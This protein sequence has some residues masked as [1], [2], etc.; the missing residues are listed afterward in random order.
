MKTIYSS[1]IIFALFALMTLATG[2]NALA[3]IASP[4]PFEFRQSDGKMVT[5]RM[6]GD[7]YVRWAETMDHYTLLHN[8]N[9]YWEYAVQDRNGDIIPS[10]L[11]AHNNDERG[12]EEISL[13]SRTE[14]SLRY[15]RQQ[16]GYLKSL[17][18][19]KQPGAAAGWNMNGT[20]KMVV[21]LIG[22]TDRAFMKT[23]TDFTN[24]MNQV[25]YNVGT[26]KGS[27][28][29]AFLEYSY[30]QFTLN[31]T[32]V[33]PYMA[34]HNEAYYGTNTPSQDYRVKELVTEA[35]NLANPVVNYAE[36]DNNNDGEAEGVYV[37]HA[38]YGEHSGGGANAIWGQMNYLNTPV[39][40]DGKTITPFTISC[41]LR[42]N[43]GTTI[44]SIGLMC[45]EFGHHLGALDYYD[46][47]NTTNGQY[48][49][50]EK[51]DLMGA[52]TWNDNGDRPSHPNPHVKSKVYNWVNATVVNS[53][54]DITLRDI[55]YYPDIYQV[56]TTTA[57]E[58]YL[59]ENKRLTGFN[60]NC[61]GE[62]ML[63][64]H[65]DANHIA[66]N[67]GSINAGPHQG[68]Y[69]MSAIS[70]TA[71]GVMPSSSS[72]INTAGC[73]WPGTGNKTTFS[74]ATV[75]NQKSWAGNNT[76]KAFINIAENGGNITFCVIGCDV[77][78]PGS[79]TV[80][81][82]SSSQLNLSWTKNPS[83]SPVMVAVNSVNSFGNPV[84][85]S[86]YS[87]GSLIAGGGTVIYYNGS[88]LGYNHT[89]LSPQTVY[90]YKVWS[91]MPGNA[92][93]AGILNNG[94][95]LCGIHNPPYTQGFS[96]TTLPECWTQV[97]NTG[98]GKFWQ[99][100]IHP[101][102]PNNQLTGNYAYMNSYSTGSPG[103]WNSDLISPLFNFSN[104][105][106]VTLQF[107]HYFESANVSVAQVSYTINNGA[108]WTPLQTWTASIAN[109]THFSQVIAGA[110]GQAQVRFKWN[111]ATPVAAYF[112]EIDNISV[113]VAP[114]VI[115]APVSNIT[116]TSAT[117]GGDVISDGGRAV[118]ARGVCWG[119]SANPTISGNHTTNGSGTGSFIAA[120]AGLPQ[121]AWLHVRA[122]ATNANGTAYGADVP[123]FTLC[124]KISSFPWNEGFENGG[125]I[126]NCWTNTQVSNSGVNW[127]FIT[128]SGNGN[129]A[130]AH[131]GTYNACLK[132]VTPPDN[133]THLT[134][135]SLNLSVISSPVLKFWH[136]QAFWEPDQDILTV[137]YKTSA[138]GA[139]TLLA[140]YTNNL[141][142]WTE[143]TI[144]L[145]QPTADYYISF[146]GNA[147]WGFGVCIDD[148]QVTG[149][150]VPLIQSLQNISV[151]PGSVACF[152]ALQ[153]ISVAGTGTTFTV[154]N[155]G[156][157]TMV[158]G[159]K[160]M[161]YPGTRVFAGG[162]MRGYI[163][164]GGPFCV[165]NIPSVPVIA[166]EEESYPGSSKQTSF[167]IYPNPTTGKFS[168]ELTGTDF[169][170]K[171]R[172][173]I[174]GMKGEKVLVKE[175]AG[176]NTHDFSLEEVPAGLYFVRVFAGEK[177][178]TMK[179][180]KY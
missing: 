30:G 66:A 152:G 125:V 169:S 90:Y 160:I 107:D 60:T 119:V 80:T 28:R 44:T 133:K 26:A 59:L 139:W 50:T 4:Y 147:K 95:T 88:G 76:N 174:Y 130:A 153:T 91:V 3:V 123:F 81:P 36:Y 63:I 10:G 103:P 127:E 124:N 101:N 79:L 58:Y 162:Y 29:D 41:E 20:N 93:S 108:T 145:P 62:G 70:T 136:T 168:L 7:E 131:G 137:Y 83:G 155:G 31:S 106:S 116:S 100:G 113:S 134:T 150:P 114:T 135:P 144:N 53:N 14:K 177:A 27:V 35:V 122:Y 176:R 178:E 164:P 11:L 140:T 72:N 40:L 118:S 52:G 42:N 156:S 12:L 24:L 142:A 22:F 13:L 68:M 9:G 49:G 99:F 48:P 51:W 129:P 87:A 16:A 120:I 149:T 85:G 82:F 18:S 56:N 73:P 172:V 105:A 180:V 179:L 163:A 112:W 121:G 132:D 5:L 46:S 17:G 57:G 138:A 167:M 170:E 43:N 143:E 102:F 84:N 159:Q 157:A 77:N 64:Y 92:Y 104:H 15:S 175:L 141:T 61:P 115:T 148:I 19:Q 2:R 21:I 126:P 158:A 173:E 1:R 75:P 8:N 128:G 94:K 166:G 54:A 34:A 96:G 78:R 151:S 32:V 86:G 38:G 161:Y 65:V 67:P 111:Y 71:S 109:P 55:T 45:H 25:G 6:M 74:D 33:G 165:S 171:V 154:L 146:E 97:D 98:T 37:V 23:Q 117:T 39:V 47:D 69:P 89:G 110:A